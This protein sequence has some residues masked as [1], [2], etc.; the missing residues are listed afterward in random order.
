MIL[1]ATHRDAVRKLIRSHPDFEAFRLANGAFK[2]RDMNRELTL[3][4]IDALG[5]L[6]Q[7]SIILGGQPI[8][9]ALPESES[10]SLESKSPEMETESQ[11]ES[12]KLMASV[13]DPLSPF[14]APTI[15]ANVRKALVP[16]V[17]QALKPA[18]ERVVT[19]TQTVDKSG[20]PVAAPSAPLAKPVAKS[21]LGKLFN[22]NRSKHAS[23]PVTIWDA[24]DAMDADPMFV[25]DASLLAAY[26][27]AAE[28]CRTVWLYGPSGAGKST[29]PMQFAAVT[30]RPFMRISFDRSTDPVDLIGQEMLDG[31]GGQHWTDGKLLRAI[32]RPGMVIL[33]DELTFAPPGLQAVIQTLTD[34][35]FFTKPNGDRVHCAN[36]V[37]FCVADNTN[38][39]G[40]TTG[41]FAGTTVS[42]AALVDRMA[43]MIRVDYLPEHL[44]SQALH[45]HVP[46]MP[47]AACEHVVVFVAGARKLDG[48]EDRPLSLRRMVAFLEALEDGFSASD[49][50]DMTFLSR[51]PDAERETLRQYFRAAFNAG[52]FQAKASNAPVPQP[53]SDAPEQVAAR[54]AFDPLV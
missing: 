2:S 29:M 31:S 26:V 46:T 3:K 15:I 7:V 8:A 11:S 38:G 10:E 20:K 27:S 25:P 16:I 4:A 49:A 39:A 36:G 9:S 53:A 32:Q 54:S 41:L 35:R 50:F 34:M 45:N 6:D 5:L 1:N 19:V 12:D 37:T 21:T 33:L 23:L 47:K 43:R 18:I 51:L 13:I 24:T 42:N 28:R 17:D 48:F 14:L 40:D 44:E 22:V 30:K 52:E